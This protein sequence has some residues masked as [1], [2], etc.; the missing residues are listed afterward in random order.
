MR[1]GKECTL[2]SDVDSHYAFICFI[3]EIFLNLHANYKIGRRK[4][5]SQGYCEE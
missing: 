3:T 4:V 1:K 2:K 5:I